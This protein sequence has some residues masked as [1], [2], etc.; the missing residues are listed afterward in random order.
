MADE[1]AKEAAEGK[2]DLDLGNMCLENPRQAEHW[3]YAPT[4]DGDLIR[5]GD[6]HTDGYQPN[7]GVQNP[8]HPHRNR[9]SHLPRLA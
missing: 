2:T 1:A 3:L 7:Q 5:T 9:G 6:R 4:K 8:T